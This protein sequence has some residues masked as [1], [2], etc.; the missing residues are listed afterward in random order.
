M[1]K[2]ILHPT[3]TSQWH[4]LLNDAQMD[5]HCFL[6][7]PVES[8]LVFLLMRFNQS[9]HLANSVLALDFMQISHTSGKVKRELLQQVG[10]K[11]LLFSGLFPGLAQ[12][13]HVSVD[14]FIQMGK[15]AYYTV[16]EQD[17]CELFNA[18]GNNFKSMRLVLSAIQN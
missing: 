4:A 11:S 6:D 2:L 17:T 5:S 7:E 10:D 13:K 12:K 8:Y 3:E 18:L 14:Y 1:E 15:T 16:A 9:P